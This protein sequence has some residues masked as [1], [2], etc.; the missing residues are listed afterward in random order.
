M[1]SREP[2][3]PLRD[4]FSSARRDRIRAGASAVVTLFL[5]ATPPALGQP[6]APSSS[7]LSDV[8]QALL[9]PFKGDWDE[10]RG[11]RM[12]R[13]LVVYSRT[14]YF[15]DRGR[16]RGATYEIL[17]ALETDL[18]AQLKTKDLKFNVVFIPVA[19]DQLIP[20]LLDGRGDLAAADLIVTPERQQRVDFTIPLRADAAEVV[21]TGPSG[22]RISS[23]EDLAG[24]TVHARRSSTYWEH[25]TALSQ[26][27]VRAGKPPLKLV[28]VS[29][30]LEDEDLLEMANAGLIPIV[31]CDVFLPRFWKPAFPKL[32]F[33][34]EVAV[35]AGQPVAWM[36]RKNSPLLKAVLDGF[37]RSHGKGTVFGNELLRR[38]EEG[39]VRR[40]LPATSETELRKFQQTVDI[41]RKYASRYDLDY[42]LMMAQGY[43]ESRLDQCA[44]SPVGAVGVMQLMPATGA[45]MNVGD[46]H[47]IEPNIHAGVKYMRQVENTYFDEP[48]LDPLMRALFTF[49]SYNAGPNRIQELRKEAAKRGLDSNRWFKNVEY[50]VAER[51]GQETVTYVSNIFKYYVAYGL[52]AQAEA[53]RQD[54]ERK[55]ESAKP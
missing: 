13:A 9:K 44:K 25:L 19:R 28:A 14:L 26:R 6:D 12:L 52:L 1:T 49:A 7:Q 55:L 51:I 11:R 22:P 34:P 53:E 17:K 3:M 5:V 36:I 32:S 24:Q 33:E 40:V 42:L 47:E 21:V 27:L 18:N 23:V 30:D 46:I 38:Y 45:Q 54:A 8:E 50:V 15:V 10:M 48:G 2:N 31:V 35:S 39:G 37:I 41:F 16:Q 29:E 4:A 20:A 43:Q